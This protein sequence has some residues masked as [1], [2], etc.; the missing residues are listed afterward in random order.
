MRQPCEIDKDCQYIKYAVCSK[1]K[2]CICKPNYI[3]VQETKCEALINEACDRDVDCFPEYSLCF[4]NKCQCH[5]NFKVRSNQ[6]CE[7]R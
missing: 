1:N 7:I 6:E 2:K 4:N 5:E 3:T